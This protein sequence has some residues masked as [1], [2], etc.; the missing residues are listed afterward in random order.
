MCSIQQ[1]KGYT[2]THGGSVE[3][4]KVFHICDYDTVNGIIYYVMINGEFLHKDS[5]LNESASGIK[6]QYPASEWK[7]P[8][9]ENVGYWDTIDEANDMIHAYIDVI[10]LQESQKQI[11]NCLVEHVNLQ[12]E[13]TGAGFDM[14]FDD[15][16]FE[17]LEVFTSSA[18]GLLNVITSIDEQ[19]QAYVNE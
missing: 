13:S 14:Q 19:T 15:D 2:I 5:S 18:K 10:T 7:R 12:L 17:S 8:A 16:N 1:Y 11:M 9:T 6:L 3:L 4:S